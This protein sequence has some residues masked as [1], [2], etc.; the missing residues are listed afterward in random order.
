VNF[1]NSSTESEE[2][3]DEYGEALTIV[4]ST[5]NNNSMTID[6]DALNNLLMKPE[7]K[8]RKVVVVSM[9]REANETNF[10][11]GYCLRCMYANVSFN[12]KNYFHKTNYHYFNCISQ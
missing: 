12:A 1:C 10:F 2:T 7:I 11:M 5:R 9:V 6:Y 8:D 3:N 4:S